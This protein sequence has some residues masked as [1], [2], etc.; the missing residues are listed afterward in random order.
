M[1]RLVLQVAAKVVNQEL[2]VVSK[3]LRKGRWSAQISRVL[4]KALFV[5]G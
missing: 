1:L 5:Q 3:I 4:C 2:T